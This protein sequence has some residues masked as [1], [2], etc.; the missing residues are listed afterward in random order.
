MFLQNLN[1]HK[2]TVVYIKKNEAGKPHLQ[3]YNPVDPYLNTV[4][5]P[6]WL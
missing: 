6:V 4:I 2:D 1:K 5:N 3:N